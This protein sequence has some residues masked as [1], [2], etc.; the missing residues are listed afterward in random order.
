MKPDGARE[1]AMHVMTS[2]AAW[3]HYHKSEQYAQRKKCGAT[4][5]VNEE[6]I[7]LLNTTSTLVSLLETKGVHHQSRIVRDA[8]MHRTSATIKCM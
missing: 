6:A 1:S 5:L 7:A 3:K 8:I 4:H 2:F